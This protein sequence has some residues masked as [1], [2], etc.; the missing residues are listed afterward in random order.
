M[1]EQSNLLPETQTIT[2]FR[3]VHVL[4]YT[5]LVVHVYVTH[6]TI[7][8]FRDVLMYTLLV[9]HVYVTHMFIVTSYIGGNQTNLVLLLG[10]IE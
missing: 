4:M 2:A 1:A 3:D 7:P 9:V 6:Q 8:A 10:G 5:L